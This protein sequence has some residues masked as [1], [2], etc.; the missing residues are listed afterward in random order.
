MKLNSFSRKHFL[1]VSSAL[2]LAMV[3][4]VASIA[5]A[6]NNPPAPLVASGSVSYDGTLQTGTSNITTSYNS[7]TGL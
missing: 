5:F 2:L 4:C 3:L 6:A 7:T 1:C